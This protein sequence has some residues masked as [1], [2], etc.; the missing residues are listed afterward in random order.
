MLVAVVAGAQKVL[1][2]R[3]ECSSRV[4]EHFP[5][6]DLTAAS[7]RKL[8]YAP[9][10]A[11]EAAKFTSRRSHARGEDEERLHAPIEA[12]SCSAAFATGN[13]LR[14]PAE[15]LSQTNAFFSFRDN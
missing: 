13:S 12:H 4:R 7:P 15:E 10:H 9:R 8:Y 2:R 6:Q 3:S 5:R 11:R 14:Q 1:A